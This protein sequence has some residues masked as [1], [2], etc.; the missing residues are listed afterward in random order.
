[1]DDDSAEHAGGW[2]HVDDGLVAAAGS[3]NRPDA[4]AVVDLGGAV[5]TPGL[6]NTHHHLWQNLTRARAQQENLFGWLQALYPVWA[7]IDEEA[8]RRLAGITQSAPLLG[9]A[10]RSY[11]RAAAAGDAAAAEALLGWIG[12]QPNVGSKYI[13]QAGMKSTI[14]KI[15][16]KLAGKH[17]MFQEGS[18]VEHIRMCADC[19][20]QVQFGDKPDPLAG[21]NRP[22]PRT[23][24]DYKRWITETHK[25]FPDIHFTMEDLVAEGDQVAVRWT[26]RGTNTGDLVTPMP[27]LATG[28][29]VTGSG[30]AIGRFAG[31]K[32]LEIWNQ[33]DTMGF[34]QQLGVI[35]TPGQAS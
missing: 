25:A 15:V 4:G 30:I 1:M 32:V 31:G 23:T 29:Q 5:V 20:V 12:A 13:R 33:G 10:L 11:R 7:A 22:V 35:P 27:L 8:E 16:A 9:P 24:E 17:S 26:D 14:D 28:K 21:P 18:A 34:L 2:I 19:R 6:V 3:G